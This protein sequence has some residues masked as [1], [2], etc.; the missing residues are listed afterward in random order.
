MVLVG[1][2]CQLQ[3]Q[4]CDADMTI[5]LHD[6]LLISLAGGVGSVA[7]TL[8]SG[9]I[10]QHR[11]P[12]LGILAVN[13]LGSFLIGMALGAVM[14]EWRVFGGGDDLRGFVIV[15][16]GFLGGFTT[17]S[18]FALQVLDLAQTG[19]GRRAVALALGSALGCPLAAF[20]GL[21]LMLVLGGGV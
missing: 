8:L 17:V 15:S 4:E 12:A 20:A 13:L 16:M 21:G 9:A 2:K 19:Q 5:T 14:A 10:S 7:R 11:H 6:L 1:A 18:T 3:Q